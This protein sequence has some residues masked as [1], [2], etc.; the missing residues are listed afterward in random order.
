MLSLQE[1]K[2]HGSNNQ[3]CDV[4]RAEGMSHRLPFSGCQVISC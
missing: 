1:N 4:Y 3:S 2:K